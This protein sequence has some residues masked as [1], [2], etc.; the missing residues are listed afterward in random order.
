M[1]KPELLTLSL[2]SFYIGIA[3]FL[4]ATKNTDKDHSTS[5]KEVSAYS[6][7]SSYTKLFGEN[8]LQFFI[9]S[10]YKPGN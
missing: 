1:M 7:S 6:G 5:S 3:C 2:I 9:Q 10:S 4:F 8:Q